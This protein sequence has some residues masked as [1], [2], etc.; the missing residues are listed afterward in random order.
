[1]FDR[2]KCFVLAGGLGICCCT[3]QAQH[4]QNTGI[5]HG[6]LD[7]WMSYSDTVHDALY[8]SG[9]GY[10]YVDSITYTP[11][12]RLQLGVWDTLGIFGNAIFTAVVYHDTLI[13]GGGFE[14]V[15]NVE[16]RGI[17]CYANGAWQPYGNFGPAPG[18]ADIYK[19]RVIDGELYAVGI[20]DQADGHLC[21]SVAK[22]VGGHW[23]NVGDLSEFTATP[24][25]GDVALFQGNLVVG[26][27]FHTPNDDLKNV[28]QFDGSTWGPL[29]LGILG[30]VA[31]GLAFAN[32]QGDLYMGGVFY[33]SAGNAGQSIMRWDGSQWHDVG[34]LQLYD[35]SDQYAASVY[36]LAVHDGLLFASGSFSFADHVPVPN[37]ATWDGIK[38]CSLGGELDPNVRAMSFYHDTLYVGCGH[39]ADGVVSNCAAKFI[40]STYQ[41]TCGTTGIE[42]VTKEVGL[43]VLSQRPGTIALTGLSDGPH[44]L[45]V[46]DA[47]GR[48]VQSKQVYSN[49]GRTGEVGFLGH[50]GPLREAL[51]GLYIIRVDGARTAKYIPMQ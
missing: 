36:S 7:T 44:T 15:N 11:L 21:N 48:L 20:F 26:G 23:E 25:I 47:Q 14:T 51:M 4:W 12:Y 33:R 29:G 24:T 17:T 19:L 1:M 8:F 37:I 5:P 39:L 46:Y 16:M 43:Q 45:Q 41:E 27:V 13:V 9:A 35:N 38:W 31:G 34:H 30:G 22:R 10:I 40:G 6:I 49:A 3:A 42:E 18:L 32:Y 28:M 50:Q 2:M